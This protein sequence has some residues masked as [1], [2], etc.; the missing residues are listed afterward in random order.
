LLAIAPSDKAR[1]W[2]GER[3]I[4]VG[5]GESTQQDETNRQALDQSVARL[6]M[7]R[8]RESAKSLEHESERAR[9]AGDEARAA[10]LLHQAQLI[11]QR[12]AAA[13]KNRGAA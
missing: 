3:M 2:L 13:Q 7:L 12:I 1:A 4:P 8:D 9:M 6:R 5:D 11:K 10:R